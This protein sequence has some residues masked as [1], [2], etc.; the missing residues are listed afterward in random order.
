MKLPEADLQ[1][2]TA[3]AFTLPSM[4]RR[5]LHCAGGGRMSPTPQPLTNWFAPR[6]RFM[7]HRTWELGT[8]L[9]KRLIT[10][11][12][13]FFFFFKLIFTVLTASVLLLS[14]ISVHTVITAQITS[15]MINKYSLY[16][17]TQSCSEE[18]V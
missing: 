2:G 8:S 14:K 18:T 13:S 3:E 5:A 7:K 4:C 9:F 6:L 16:K 12:I 17:K 1:S 11:V 10:K 15:P